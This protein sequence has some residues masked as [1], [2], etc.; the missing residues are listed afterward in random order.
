MQF[1]GLRPGSMAQPGAGA[2]IQ[3]TDGHRRVRPF[4]SKT[5]YASVRESL[6][7]LSFEK[8]R[9]TSSPLRSLGQTNWVSVP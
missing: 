5:V 9:K 1:N 6:P 2:V 7:V 8:N 3:A 4:N